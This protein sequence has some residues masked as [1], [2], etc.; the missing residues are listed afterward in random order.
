VVDPGQAPR[1]VAPAT[2]RRRLNSACSVSG[3][4]AL[5]YEWL[6]SA[7]EVVQ[8][9]CAG[10]ESPAAGGAILLGALRQSE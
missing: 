6:V 8:V 9:L 2:A 1:D 3:A 4:C 5:A 7:P 10:G